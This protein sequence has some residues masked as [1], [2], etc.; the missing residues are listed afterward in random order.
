MARVHKRLRYLLTRHPLFY[1]VRFAWRARLGSKEIFRDECSNDHCRENEIPADFRRVVSRLRSGGGGTFE[2]AKKIAFDLSHGHRAGRGLSCDSVKALRVIYD[3]GGGICSDYSQV[4]LG[5]CIAAGIRARE[6]GVCDDLRT[7]SLGHTCNEV[8]S[9]EHD[10]WVFID[11]FNSIYAEDRME[12]L[13]LSVTEVV[14]SITALRPRQIEFQH[15]DA[16]RIGQAVVP[17]TDLYLQPSNI[18]F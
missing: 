15:I 12:H 7:P 17:L 5:L 13:P 8:Y 4:Y 1:R 14:D 10:K 2:K 11:T 18:F 3:G 16:E 9:T 6:W